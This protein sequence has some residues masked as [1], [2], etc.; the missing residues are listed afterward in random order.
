MW[1][2][3][4]IAH[5]LDMIRRLPEAELRGWWRF[6][7]GWREPFPGEIAAL[8]QRA[9]RLG[10]TLSSPAAPSASTTAAA[11]PPLDTNGFTSS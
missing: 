5:K 7:H 11:P 9:Q 2:Q 4:E 1:S 3:A 8:H 6:V 10:V